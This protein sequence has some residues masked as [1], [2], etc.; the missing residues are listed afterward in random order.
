MLHFQRVKVAITILVGLALF[1]SAFSETQAKRKLFKNHRMLLA[2][3]AARGEKDVLILIASRNGSNASVVDEIKSL[4]GEVHYREDSVDYLR[5]RVPL[6]SVEKLAAFEGVESL[7]LDV[8]IDKWDPRFDDLFPPEKEAESNNPPDPDTPL[9]HPYIPLEDMNIERVSSDGINF[10]GRGTGVAILDATPDFLLPELQYATSLDGQPVRKISGALASTDPRD[11]NDPMWIKMDAMVKAEDGKFSYKEI[12]YTA[13]SNGE[14]RLGFFNERSL[15]QPA[16]LYSDVNFDGNPAGSTGVF[17]VLWDER[18]NTVWVDTDQDH[19]FQNEKPMMDYDRRMDLGIFGKNVPASRR[20]KTVA[21]AVQTDLEKK[22]VR[23][24]LGVWQHVTEVA[25][26]S[27]GKGFYGG[28]YDGVAPGAQL[29]SVYNSP[30]AIFRLVEGAI[31]A[32]KSPK[33]DVICLEPSILDPTIN[34]L[35]DG[36]LVAGTIFDRLIEKYKKPIL[37]PANNEPGLNTVVDEVSSNKIIAVGAYQAGEAYRVNNGAEVKEHDN[38]HIVGS[39]GPA[40]DGGLKPEILSPSE[41]ISTDPAYKPAEKRKG[42]YELPPG[43][44]VAGGTSTAGPTASAAA[45]ILVSAAKQAGIAYDAARIRT[46]MLSSARFIPAIPAY[47]QGNG[48]VQVGAAWKMLRLMDKNF[49]PMN[50]VSE[51]PVR[52]AISYDLAKP[53]VGRGIYEREGWSPHQNG[54]RTITFTRTTGP[55]EPVEFHVQWVGNDGTFKSDDSIKL[56]LNTPV[57]LPVSITVEGL[58]VHS[59]ILN[60]RHESDPW[61]TYQVLNTVVVAEDF[62]PESHYQM[63]YE[64]PVKR[65]GSSSIFLRV[66]PNTATLRLKVQTPDAKPTLRVSVIAPDHSSRVPFNTLGVTKKGVLNSTVKEP[67]PGVW[68]IVF[69]G[70]NFVFFPEQIDSKPL[71]AVPTK[72]TATLV[73]VTAQDSTCRISRTGVQ[74]CASEVTFSNVLGPFRGR[75]KDSAIGSA[76]QATDTIVS[77]ARRVYE[78]DVPPGSEDAGASI[79]QFSNDASLDLYLFQEVKGVVVLRDSSCGPGT[80]KRVGVINPEAGRWKVVVDAYNVPSGSARYSYTDIFTHRALGTISVD[81]KTAV[82]ASGT[83]WKVHPKLNLYAVPSGDRVLLGYVPVRWEEE[84]TI[85]PSD[86]QA[87]ERNI[88][89]LEAGTS[90]GLASFIFK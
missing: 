61:I 54:K 23:I 56:P 65:P 33:V 41:L 16:Y 34:P 51:A 52:T 38:L 85:D 75:A 70:N 6:T 13:P 73:G 83:Q 2:L 17:A 36:R 89:D 43:Y 79:R 5:A 81:D 72:V 42:V 77:G 10:D 71:T 22:Y 32:A 7:D 27:L 49:A 29:F 63:V 74:G 4:G 24:T 84:Q 19:S 86:L 1:T 25:G 28:T 50:V 62:K 78:F 60:L 9:S 26:A 11:D 53:N 31:I 21:F 14:Y 66:P 64:L 47:K 90:V 18:K 88:Q 37:S 45:A 69:Y 87:F 8:D 15:H 3:S 20:R 59:A 57:Q 68:E 80:T 55:Q 35:H 48:L 76:R 30:P 39:Y 12:S 67:S 44:S 40:G 82:H 58:G 46:A